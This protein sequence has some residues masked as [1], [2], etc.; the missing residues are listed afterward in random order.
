MQLP[1]WDFYSA[2]HILLQAGGFCCLS[3]GQDN[4]QQEKIS[5]RVLQKSTI[6]PLWDGKNMIQLNLDLLTFLEK[7]DKHNQLF[8]CE[9]ISLKIY[10]EPKKSKLLGQDYMFWFVLQL[11]INVCDKP[12]TSK[13]L[14]GFKPTL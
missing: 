8:I 2:G 9:N 6:H 11:R 12:H 5:C 4:N 14:C 13:S 7:F 10:R 3:A 1:G